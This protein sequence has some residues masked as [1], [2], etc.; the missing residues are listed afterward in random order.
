MSGIVN[1]TRHN[2]CSYFKKDNSNQTNEDAKDGL[3]IMRNY[4]IEIYMQL[5]H[6]TSD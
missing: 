6:K 4:E 1:V 2:E 5:A 3:N